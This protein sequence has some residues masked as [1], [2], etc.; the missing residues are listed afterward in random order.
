MSTAAPAISEARAQ[1]LARKA[2]EREEWEQ[3]LR[4]L[5]AKREAKRMVREA[6]EAERRAQRA[7]REQEREAERQLGALRQALEDAADAALYGPDDDPT[8]P[9][10]PRPADHYE[11][12]LPPR[13]RRRIA[14]WRRERAQPA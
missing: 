3:Y 9:P 2:A 4:E 6:A 11:A 14:E 13:I 8:L 1:Y 7:Q 12:M 10:L 5:R